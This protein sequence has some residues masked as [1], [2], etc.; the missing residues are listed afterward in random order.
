[1]YV[2][3]CAF[4][5]FVLGFWCRFAL[6]TSRAFTPH[7]HSHSP[8]KN[9]KNKNKKTTTNDDDGGDDDGDDDDSEAA[10]AAA[11]DYLTS[12]FFPF[13]VTNNPM[14]LFHFVNEYSTG[15]LPW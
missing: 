2:S 4:V 13:G 9:N 7:T 5:L 15:R 3:A 1:M 12:F 10:A 11:E 6:A 8:E 14:L